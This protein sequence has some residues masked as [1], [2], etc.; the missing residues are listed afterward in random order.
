VLKIR[1]GT[2][3]AKIWLK[4]GEIIDA[5]TGDLSGE[6]AFK[7]ILHWKTGNFETLPADPAHPCA[8]YNSYQSLLLAS[9]QALDEAKGPP[10]PLTIPEK[11]AEATA[12][13]LALLAQVNGVEFALRT[14]IGV[15]SATEVWAVEES[16]SLAKWAQKAFADFGALGEHLHAGA[17]TEWTGYGLRNHMTIS[18]R[19]NHLLC[20][21]FHHSMSEVQVRETTKTII[22][23]WES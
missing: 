6:A 11:P 3:E 16:E 12:R 20:L 15:P 10:E 2:Q 8:I 5:V 13:P 7:K 14:S 4:N 17:V 21:G 19:G 1:S 18:A 23:K 22:A 9:A